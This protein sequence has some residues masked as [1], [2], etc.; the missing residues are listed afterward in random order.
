MR[1]AL[2]TFSEVF[3]LCSQS[4]STVLPRGSSLRTRVASQV[5][6]VEILPVSAFFPLYIVGGR[7]IVLVVGVVKH[8]VGRIVGRNAN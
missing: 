2:T 3:D 1:E 6:A 7:R 4:A 8:I 5:Y